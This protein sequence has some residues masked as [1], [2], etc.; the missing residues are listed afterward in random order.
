MDIESQQRNNDEPGAIG[1]IV[2]MILI[3]ILSTISGSIYI[4][5]EMQNNILWRPHRILIGFVVI[6]CMSLFVC[7]PIGGIIEVFITNKG[8]VCQAI[9]NSYKATLLCIC[10]INC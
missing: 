3:A 10:S 2:F 5:I 4:Y 6:A 7:V 8:T 1:G 9:R